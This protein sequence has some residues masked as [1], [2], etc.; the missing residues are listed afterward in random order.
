MLVDDRDMTTTATTTPAR[1]R[2]FRR[3]QRRSPGITLDP[4][5]IDETTFTLSQ[6]RCARDG[7]A[8]SRRR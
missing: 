3:S 2:P 5:W 4:I 6:I 8:E 7:N 1:Q